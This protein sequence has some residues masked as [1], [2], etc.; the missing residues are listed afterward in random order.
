MLI[1]IS[2]V[3][4]ERLKNIPPSFISKNHTACVK[5]K[6]SDEGDRLMS[7]ILEISDNLKIKGFLMTLD[8]EKYF[9]TQRMQMVLH[10]SLKTKNL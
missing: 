1:L 4:A 9:Y 6:F 7:D 8:T 5:G 2:N 10:C 3:L